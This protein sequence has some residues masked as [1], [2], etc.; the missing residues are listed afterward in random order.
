MAGDSPIQAIS[1]LKHRGHNGFVKA[2]KLPRCDYYVKDLNCLIEFDESRHFTVPRSLTL[3][4]CPDTL[5]LG[6]SRNERISKC[7]DLD[8]HDNHPPAR[9]ETR[10]WYDTLRDI[11]PPTLRMSPTIRNYAKDLKWC[12]ASHRELQKKIKQLLIK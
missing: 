7:V 4:I 11:L 5:K 1:L 10:A 3:S 2:K 9:D 12:D 8:R 6:F